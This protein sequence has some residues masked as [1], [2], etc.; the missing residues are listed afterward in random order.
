LIEKNCGLFA[1]IPIS[2]ARTHLTYV[3]NPCSGEKNAAQPEVGGLAI[4]RY[5]RGSS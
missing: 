4:W 2:I 1:A 5:Q 3:K